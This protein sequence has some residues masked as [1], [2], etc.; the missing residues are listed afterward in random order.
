MDS[1]EIRSAV[2]ELIEAQLDL[3]DAKAVRDTFRAANGP[4]AVPPMFDGVDDF[5]QF[6]MEQTRF[7]GEL[8]KVEE[9]IETKDRAFRAA[10]ANVQGLLPDGTPLYHNYEGPRAEAKGE[11]F[12][13]LNQGGTFTVRPVRQR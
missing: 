13:V 3:E 2:N 1:V 5:S 12:M 9:A 6:V 8:A 11:R 10:A 7:E 4:P